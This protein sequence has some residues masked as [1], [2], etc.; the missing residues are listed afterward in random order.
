MILPKLKIPRKVQGV[1]EKIDVISSYNNF[2]LIR[3]FNSMC[4]NK[5]KILFLMF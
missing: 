4:R 1:S 5:L 3:I 2:Q